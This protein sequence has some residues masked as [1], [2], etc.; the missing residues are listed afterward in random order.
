MTEYIDVLDESGKKTGTVK[1]RTDVHNDGDWHRAACVWI[2]NSNDEILLQ[3]RVPHKSYPNSWANSVIGHVMAGD[4]AL[5]TAMRETVEELGV[6]L[7]KESFDYIGQLTYYKGKEFFDCYIVRIDL[8]LSEFK[9]DPV[10]ATEIKFFTITEIVSR[11]QSQDD[12]FRAI[13]LEELQLLL[14]KIAI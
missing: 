12:E 4:T 7:T 11:I 14:D 2:I 9:F 6:E 5:D 13:A 3:R 10:E 1:S 8:P